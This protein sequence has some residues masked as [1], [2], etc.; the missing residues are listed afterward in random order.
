M[1]PL[2][3]PKLSTPIRT[4]DTLVRSTLGASEPASMR[5]I[6]PLWVINSSPI[7]PFRIRPLH[8]LLADQEVMQR[9]AIVTA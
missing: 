8:H 2:R 7:P 9:A 3:E 1:P 4:L 6:A 5:R